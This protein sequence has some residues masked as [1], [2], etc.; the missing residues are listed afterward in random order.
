MT[1]RKI[2]IAAAVTSSFAAPAFAQQQQVTVE[3]YC[4]DPTNAQTEVCTTY[5]NGSGFEAG[6]IGI[7]VGGLFILAA[8][9]SG[10]A[11]ASTTTD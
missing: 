7:I 8:L 1:I 5:L 9:A 10:G 6:T 4:A 11:T 2:L 3:E